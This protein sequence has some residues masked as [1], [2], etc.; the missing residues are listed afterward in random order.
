M[1]YLE[2]D[3]K[4]ELVKAMR[5]AGCEAQ[6]FPDNARGVIK[7]YDLVLG[8]GGKLVAVETK[9]TKIGSARS[10]SSR[11]SSLRIVKF[12]DV[13]FNQMRALDLT[14]MNGSLAFL[15]AG[16][17]EQYNGDRECWMIPWGVF[18]TQEVWTLG[19]LLHLRPPRLF[20]A[21]G[22]GWDVSALIEYVRE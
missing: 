10:F 6:K 21:K 17:Y 4:T 13:R 1:S 20:W 22:R 2:R 8:I 15:G 9:L 11:T 16:V 18:K 12:S 19:D 7:P 14:E 5:S 3:L